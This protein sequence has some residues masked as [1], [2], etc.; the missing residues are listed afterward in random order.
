[1]RWYYP[2]LAAPIQVF[3]YLPLFVLY[4]FSDVIYVLMYYVIGYRRKVV[5][6]NL[7]NAFPHYSTGKIIQIEKAYYKYMVDLIFET[8]KLIS[9]TPKQLLGR[10][11]FDEESTKL[12]HDR[13][14]QNKSCIMVLGHLGNW[15]WGGQAFGCLTNLHVTGIYHP[16]SSPFFEWLTYKFRS[17]YATRMIPM[18]TVL[19]VMMKEQNEFR[20]TAF[21]A[22]QTPLPEHAYW[23]NFLNQDTPVFTGTEKLAKRFNQSVIYA[24]CVKN[25]RGRY[26]VTF[27][28]ITDNPAEF[29]EEELTQIH[30][31]MLERDIIKQPEIWLWSHKRWKH[32]R[33]PNNT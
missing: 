22:D 33:N 9:F 19:K 20:I 17:R 6:T 12:F 1:M 24:G 27:E 11:T 18:S 13:A 5:R 23:V 26:H 32:K 29:K 30:T 3:F 15:E 25:G 14:K 2:I 4:R 7:T 10:M 28:L 16:L 31:A 21:I 8:L